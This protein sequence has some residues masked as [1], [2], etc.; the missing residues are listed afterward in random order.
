VSD[1]NFSSEYAGRNLIVCCDGTNNQFGY[2][3]TNV[4]R[5]VQVL[6]RDHERQRLYYQAGVG[7]LPHDDP[8]RQ[9]RTVFRNI[10]GGTSGVGVLRNVENAY[11]FL[12]EVWEEGDRIYLF[13]F[14]RGAYTVRVLAGLLHSV[15]LIG[16]GS[17]EMIPYALQIYNGLSNSD[18]GK[19]NLERWQKLCADFRWTFARPMCERDQSRSCRIHFV[20]V[21]DTVSSVG[22]FRKPLKF[23]HTTSNS[24]IDVI[25]H[26]IAIDERRAFFRQNR[27]F[28][29]NATQNLQEIWFPG[30]HSDIGGG[31][32]PMFSASLSKSE[33]WK[34]SFAWIVSEAQASGLVVDDTRLK[35]VLGSEEPA[36][37][38]WADPIHDSLEGFWR[39]LEFV[40]RPV[41]N[42]EERKIEWRR[43]G[44]A[45][46]SIAEGALIDRS[47]LERLRDPSL[48]YIP[49]NISEQFRQNVSS[50]AALPPVLPYKSGLTSSSAGATHTSIRNL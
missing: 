8:L 10:L 11:R 20:G 15:G 40:K 33:L 47:A 42:Y 4:V 32:P 19:D 5:L 36:R 49:P 17:A 48:K 34:L 12:M 7:T 31:Y 13:G 26:A 22:W 1:T 35:E 39:Y 46:R 9:R 6:D 45:Y 23:P 29:A 37:N 30:V 44:S 16:H 25:R 2:V 14:S 41:W 28:R 43:G 21:W 27:F 3:N 50:L 38:I 24:S 18:E